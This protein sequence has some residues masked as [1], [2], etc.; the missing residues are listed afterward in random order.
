LS[1]WWGIT[2]RTESGPGYLP[3]VEIVNPAQ[4]DREDTR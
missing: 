3:A 4:S 1:H 2:I